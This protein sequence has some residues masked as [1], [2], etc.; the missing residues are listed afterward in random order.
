MTV[1]ANSPRAAAI[2]FGVVLIVGAAW[3]QPVQLVPLRPVVPPADAPR[4][5]APDS[6]AGDQPVE[7]RQPD[8]QVQVLKAPDPSSVGLLDDKNGGLDLDLWAGSRRPLVEQLIRQLPAAN[9]SAAMQALLKQLLLTDAVVPVGPAGTPALVTLRA[10]RLAA[11]GDY[12]D[13]LQLAQLA[14]AQIKDIGLTRILVDQKL[15]TGDDAA[16]CERIQ[17]LR[18]SDSD[19]YWFKGS[20]Y[21]RLIANDQSQIGFD[22]SLLREQ[23]AD[24]AGFFLLVGAL[25]GDTTLKIDSLAMPTP[26]H[27]AMLRA[28]KRPLPSAAINNAGPAVLAAVNSLPTVEPELRLAAAER[29][30]SFGA[31]SSEPLTRLY[32]ASEFSEAQKAS[33]PAATEKGPRAAALLF[34]MAGA[35]RTALQ[36]ADILR[37]ALSLGRERGLYATTARANL[38]ALQSIVP[39]PELEPMAP[40]LVRGLLAAGD[41]ASAR[42]WWDWLV[43]RNDDPL[44]VTA[45]AALWPLLLIAGTPGLDAADDADFQRWIDTQKGADPAL[46]D[47]R[48]AALA[49][50]FDA[51]DYGIAPE[52]LDAAQAIP[53][54]PEEVVPPPV[55]SRGLGSAGQAKRRGE[56]ILYALLVLGAGGPGSADAGTAAAAVDALHGVGLESAARAIAL[57]AALARGI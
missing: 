30:E 27:L 42:V 31:L 51:L 48:T 13:A 12:A 49:L 9:R 18:R 6:A 50:L 19:I 14:G 45:R 3:A 11:A 39:T 26:L 8:I 56:T 53:V 37:R 57:E 24:D 16:A 44:A 43:S 38:A 54:G 10:E 41:T 5:D 32:A 36:R 7:P 20:L 29:A 46:R 25:Q 52:R 21:C 1:W 47:R 34:Q 33:G 15:L 17:A 35:P 28:S 23:G 40:D 2:A 55:L 22:L 4:T